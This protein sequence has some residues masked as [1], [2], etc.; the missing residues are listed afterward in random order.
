MNGPSGN[1][2]SSDFAM[3]RRYLR[4]KSAIPSGQGSAFERWFAAST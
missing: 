3:K 4:G 2:N 1:Q